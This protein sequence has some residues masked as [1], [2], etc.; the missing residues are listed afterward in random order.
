MIWLPLWQNLIIE[1]PATEEED[2]LGCLF[3]LNL[4][5]AFN[6]VEVIE[7]QLGI[8]EKDWE[9]CSM[10]NVGLTYSSLHNYGVECESPFKRRELLCTKFKEK[11]TRPDV[12]NGFI[13]FFRL[14]RQVFAYSNWSSEINSTELIRYY[15]P[16]MLYSSASS[17]TFW[18]QVN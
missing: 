14:R 5:D 9:V 8:R 15:L 11:R 1:S 13:S 7:E 3:L 12:V 16:V 17:V 4:V 10:M 6:G 18:V 2:I